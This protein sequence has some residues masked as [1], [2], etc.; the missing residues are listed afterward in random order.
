MCKNLKGD[1]LER[2]A[3]LVR[4]SVCIW[5]ESHTFGIVTCKQN[6]GFSF[7][8]LPAFCPTP[9]HVEAFP[10]RLCL[11]PGEPQP[12]RPGE[13]PP[14]SAGSR[15][16]SPVT[17]VW[18]LVSWLVWQVH[19][20]R[21]KKCLAGLCGFQN[22]PSFHKMTREHR[23]LLRAAGFLWSPLLLSPEGQDQGGLWQWILDLQSKKKFRFKSQFYPLL[24]WWPGV[25][26]LPM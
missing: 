23:V 19:S 6:A 1:S 7:S 5:N 15:L 24:L 2:K 14:R 26:L 11:E 18:T 9:G 21:G 8:G 4:F 22:M 13:P 16:A 20:S 10:C 17:R 12:E 25:K 3:K